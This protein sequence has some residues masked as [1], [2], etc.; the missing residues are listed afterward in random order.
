MGTSDW[1]FIPLIV[2]VVHF[3]HKAEGW[4][5]GIHVCRYA[6]ITTIRTGLCS[7]WDFSVKPGIAAA[8]HHRFRE[9]TMQPLFLL[10]GSYCSSGGN[11]C[12]HSSQ[13]YVKK[14]KKLCCSLGINW[15]GLWSSA[16]DFSLILFQEVHSLCRDVKRNRHKNLNVAARRDASVMPFFW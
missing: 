9:E 3:A 10:W 6:A 14:K 7:L 11:L 8:L 12:G 4:F 5:G 13:S 2:W 1:D 16:H 15:R